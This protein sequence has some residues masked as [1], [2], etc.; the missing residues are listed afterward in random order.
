M[1]GRITVQEIIRYHLVVFDFG[2]EPNKE[3]TIDPEVIQLIIQHIKIGG[4][5]KIP[6][7]F[8]NDSNCVR[9][10]FP[11]RACNETD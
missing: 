4:G 11:I 8:D 5:G 2:G 3:T 6:A 10:G 9:N 1:E 7:Y